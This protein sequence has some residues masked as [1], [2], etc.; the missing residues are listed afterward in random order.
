ME[1][2]LI[3][4]SK[5]TPERFYGKPTRH[6][7]AC[8]RIASG[9]ALLNGS[10]VD[11]L[12]IP[13]PCPLHVSPPSPSHNYERIVMEIPT[14]AFLS[15]FSSLGLA[16]FSRLLRN[17]SAR[18][19]RASAGRGGGLGRRGFG[20]IQAPLHDLEAT[21]CDDRGNHSH[22]YLAE[23]LKRFGTIFFKSCKIRAARG[24]DRQVSVGTRAITRIYCG[25]FLS[26][27]QLPY[28]A[29]E[30]TG[31]AFRGFGKDI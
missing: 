23:R 12:A 4:R 8:G 9:Y 13:E 22:N 25:S 31:G 6:D 7:S 1:R 18:L 5:A 30:R 24:R 2:A 28:D 15:D 3:F 17:S 21:A 10:G 16:G 27:I 19:L 20:V 14:F 26:H 29:S 11:P